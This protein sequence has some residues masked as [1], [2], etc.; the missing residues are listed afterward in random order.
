MCGRELRGRGLQLLWHRGQAPKPRDGRAGSSSMQ[1]PDCS[2]PAREMLQRA[3]DDE[4][5]I[6]CLRVSPYSS[7]LSTAEP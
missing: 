5:S 3:P 1:A 7:A 2:S 6:S 4:V